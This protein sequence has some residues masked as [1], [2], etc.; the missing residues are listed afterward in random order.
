MCGGVKWSVWGGKMAE[1]AASHT[2]VGDQGSADNFRM[3]RLGGSINAT[4]CFVYLLIFS[5]HPSQVFGEKFIHS[6][7]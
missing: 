6:I 3:G 4:G 1:A 5:T 7:F 2:G